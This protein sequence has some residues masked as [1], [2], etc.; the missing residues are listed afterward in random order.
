M[1]EDEE[2]VST[3][4]QEEEHEHE[5]EQPMEEDDTPHLDLEGGREMQAYNLI[6]NYEFVHMPLYDPALLQAI[7]VDVKIASIWKAI[8]WEEVDPIWEQGSRLL[9][10]QFLCSIKEVANGTTFRLFEVEY[11]CTWKD[12][13]QHIGFQRR[14]A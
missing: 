5:Q 2:T 13:G 14:Y 1:H 3:E 6:K 7:C 4:E 10:I 9:T 8:G 12:L 11:F